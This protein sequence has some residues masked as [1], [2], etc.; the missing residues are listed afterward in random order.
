MRQLDPGRY[1]LKYA[2]P[3][4]RREELL[5]AAGDFMT[6]DTHAFPLEGGGWGY[7]V[8]STYFDTV[9]LL[10]YTSRLAEHRV[11]R[12]TRIRTYGA[13][14]DHA[15][16]FLELKRKLDDQVIK[17]RDKV[18]DADTWATLGERP[19][20]TL[21]D[22]ADPDIRAMALRFGDVVQQRALVPWVSVHYHREVYID[23]RKGF[24]KVRLTIDRQI[25]GSHAHTAQNL[26]PPPEFSL[27]PDDLCVVELKFDGAQPPW[28]STIVK[29]LGLYAEPISKYGLTVAHSARANHPNELRWLLPRAARRR[30]L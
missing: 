13:P 2:I 3:L 20:E 7:I 9:D 6:A 14:G 30:L 16:V 10:D 25:T 15:P 17:Q 5:A 29:R 26:Y 12:R 22:A 18:S 8:H 27:L 23:V 4:S 24:H 28:M 21:Y 19:W 1:E 11:R